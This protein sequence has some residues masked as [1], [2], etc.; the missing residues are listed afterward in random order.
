MFIKVIPEKSTGRELMIFCEST[1]KN[2]KRVQKTVERIG[3]VDEF[4][5]KYEDPVAHFKEEARK[6]TKEA[7][8]KRV[9]LEY[10]LDQRFSFNESFNKALSYEVVSEDLLKSYGSLVLLKLYRELELDYF[11]NYKSQ[12]SKAKY[13]HNHIFQLL[14]FGRILSPNSKLATWREKNKLLQTSSFSDDDLYRSLPFFASIKDEMISHLHKSVNRRSKRRASLMYYDVTNYYWEIDDE[15]ELRKKGPCK[16][17]RPEPIVQMGLFMDQDALP[18]S[19]ALFPGNTN[20]VLTM[21]PMMDNIVEKLEGLDNDTLVYV[22]DKGISSGY[23]IAQIILDQNGYVISD[24]VRKS[25]KAMKSYILDQDG[26]VE[27][28]DGSFKYKGRFYPREL[29]IENSEGKIEYVKVNERQVVFWSKKYATKAKQERLKAVTKALVKATSG[30][31]TILNNFGGNRYIKKLIFDSSTDRHIEEPQ[32][33]ID[34]DDDL[35]AQEESL[36]GYYIIRT[37]VVSRHES[38]SLEAFKGR[39]SRWIAKEALLE[40]NDEI[41]DLDIID[42]YRGLWQIEES[43]KITKSILKTRPIFV[44]NPESIEA[45]FLSCFVALLML[46]LLESKCNYQIPV[47]TMVDSL[48]KANLAQLPNETFQNIYCDNVIASIARYLDLDLTKR[49]YSKADLKTLRGKTQKSK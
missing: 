29:R 40:M 47:A 6:R 18:V 16:E 24:S 19:Y 13:N 12:Y 17:H 42:I 26:Y 27:S 10:S 45:H 35:I 1:H 48:R 41:T 34:I 22:A 31:N 39:D 46:R 4:T 30:K 15:D 8:E 14:V 33:A 43:F 7:K 5:D 36:D 25:T 21:K 3:Y 32:F 49:F 11:L 38:T 20:D 44:K 37:N 2:G 28:E 9:S 23:N